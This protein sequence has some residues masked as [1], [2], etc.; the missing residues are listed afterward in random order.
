MFTGASVRNILHNPFYMGR[1]RHRDQILP[2][3]HDGLVPEDVYQ[4]VQDAMRRNSGRSQTLQQ[5]PKREYLLKGLIH[6]AHCRMP[7]WAQTFKNG[8]RYYREQKG[9]RGAGYCVSRSGSM[10]GEV[11]DEQMG[12]IISAIVLPEA[13]LDRVLAQ[14][15]GADEVKRVDREREQ[16]Q[17]RL[18][19]LG[20]AYVDGMYDDAEYRRQ[21]RVLDDKLQSLVVPDADVAADA[22]KLLE[23]L[24]ELWEHADLAERHRILVTML[25][26]VYVDTVDERR[27]VA[28]RPRP[29]FRPLLEIATMR[30]GS[31]IVLVHDRA[32]D[33]EKPNQPPP[34]GQ[35][36]DESCSWWRRGREPVSKV[37]GATSLWGSG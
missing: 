23:H 15:H 13:W 11:P 24:P 9:S 27:I 34:G 12:R 8:R 5:R 10:P 33:T 31:G 26:A 4:T 20:T 29:A 2:G 25:D 17:Q 37:G 3:A 1:I 14:V 16:V 6:C 36:A 21:K 22:G 28:I 35:E 19:R 7:M 18:K 30:A 32:G